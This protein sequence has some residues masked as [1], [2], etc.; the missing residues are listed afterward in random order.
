[1]SKKKKL[2]KKQQIL[3]VWSHIARY[4]IQWRYL[5]ISISMAL[6]W[7]TIKNFT[8]FSNFLSIL[9]WRLIKEYLALL[10][11]WPVAVLVLG[12]LFILKFSNSIRLF[13]EKIDRMKA[14]GVELSQQQTAIDV[15][16]KQDEEQKDKVVENLESQASDGSATLTKDEID[17]LVEMFETMDFKYLNLH[18]VQNT[19]NALKLMTGT[20]VKEAT[21]LQIYQV[22]PQVGDAVR[23]RQ[24][25]L[26][27]LIVAGLAINNSGTLK[28]TDKGLR[29]L[30]FIGLG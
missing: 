25:I 8:A 16:S 2:T 27:E 13:L 6:I 29:F 5:W 23:E 1:M 14:L 3:K 4:D 20:E 11:T 10:L 22:S 17:Q 7:Y 26:N 9:D 30:K 15:G 24:A 12:L 28:V 21:F 19:K 18:L